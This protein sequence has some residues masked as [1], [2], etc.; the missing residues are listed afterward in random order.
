MAIRWPEKAEFAF[1]GGI[2]ATFRVSGLGVW[3]EITSWRLE[4]GDRTG[5]WAHGGGA[6]L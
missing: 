1:V 4:K 3:G 2:C 5:V 6:H